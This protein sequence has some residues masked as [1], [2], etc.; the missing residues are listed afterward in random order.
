[1]IHKGSYAAGLAE[2]VESA[3]SREKISESIASIPEWEWKY[4]EQ[5]QRLP[6]PL[7][8]GLALVFPMP[9]VKTSEAIDRRMTRLEAFMIDRYRV[10]KPEQDEQ[11]RLSEVRERIAEWKREGIPPKLFDQWRV[12]FPE[13]WQRDLSETRTEVGE[14][15]Q[16]AKTEKEGKQGRVKSKDDKR[17]GARPPVL[18]PPEETLGT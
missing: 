16:Q 9:G 12:N 7:D 4:G 10:A 14:K 17:L 5:G 11:E 15:G 18:K 1:M 2:F 13:W 6:V 3:K 8:K